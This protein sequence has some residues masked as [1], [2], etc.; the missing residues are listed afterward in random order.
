M[1]NVRVLLIQNETING[2]GATLQQIEENLKTEFSSYNYMIGFLDG[3]LFNKYKLIELDR[4][5][6]YV[7]KK[8]NNYNDYY[9]KFVSFQ[10][11]DRIIKEED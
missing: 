11:D 4:Y 8:G 6:T 10:F 3:Y 1:N 5:E 9:V 7:N 2:T